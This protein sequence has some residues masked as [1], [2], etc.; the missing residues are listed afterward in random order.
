MD[1]L[2]RVRYDSN[3]NPTPHDGRYIVAW[4]PHTQYGTLALTS[5]SDRRKARRA[6]LA[7]WLTE[8]KTISRVQPR[9]PDGE[10]NRPLCGINIELEPV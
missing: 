4:N 6:P 1:A 3:N 2:V 10:P 5:T 8:R 7:Q 9:R